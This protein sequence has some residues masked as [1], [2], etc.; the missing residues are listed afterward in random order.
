MGNR[1][2]TSESDYRMYSRPV[3]GE[4]GDWVEVVD[5]GGEPPRVS[6]RTTHTEAEF[7]D[8]DVDGAAAQ[9][10]LGVA[11]AP[12]SRFNP[13]L[14]AAWAVVAM[15]LV[16]GLIWLSGNLQITSAIYGGGSAVTSA[17]DVAMMNFQMMGVYLLPFGLAGAL[18]LLMLQAAG[19][20]RER[21]V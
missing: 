4:S 20:R 15:M 6:S 11:A 8:A 16:L 17:Q 18:A 10:P 14:C 12:R 7:S 13:Y 1:R 19:Y 21:R 9:G 3:P 5:D 2:S